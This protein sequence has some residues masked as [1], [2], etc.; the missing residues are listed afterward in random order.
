MKTALQGILEHFEP[1]VETVHEPLLVLDAT[2]QVKLASRAFCAISGNE[3][4]EVI[5]ASLWDIDD[6]YWDVP[7]IRQLLETDLK[8]TPAIRDRRIELESHKRPRQVLTVNARFV[9][10]YGVVLFT[11]ANTTNATNVAPA[12]AESL[13]EELEARVRER[14]QEL[15]DER[16]IALALAEK[17]EEAKVVAIE[18]S[19]ALQRS[20]AQLRQSQK[21]EA[22]GRLAGGV[23][24]DF[25]N[26][27]TVILSCSTF[28]MQDLKPEEQA[29]LDILEIRR[30]ADRAASLTRQLLQF[31][32]KGSIEPQ[33]FNPNEKIA[34]LK[35]MLARLLG[36]DVELVTHLAP[37]LGCVYIDPTA[38]EQIVVNLAVNARDAMP[39]GGRLLIESNVAHVDEGYAAAAKG[40]F[41]PPGEYVTVSVSDTGV[42][43]DLSMQQHIF[44]PFFT[45]K[46]V[47][48]G[49]GLGLST[50][51][52]IAKQA[53]GYVSVYSELGKGT[54]FRVYLAR[55]DMPATETRERR[56]QATYTGTEAVLVVE[57]D[58]QIRMLC[59]RALS[60]AGY[61][62]EVVADGIEALR[63]CED[64][65][66][67]FDLLLT[68][69]VMPGMSGT[70][71][72]S[73]LAKT[74]PDM[75]LLFM[76]GY[77]PNAIAP[78]GVSGSAVA[79][80]A[81]PF[82]LA[83]LTKSIREVLDTTEAS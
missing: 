42:G 67:V 79:L 60:G 11:I 28:V 19:K 6:G 12:G 74:R 13:T 2:M 73:R 17:A 46:E 36:E 62:V 7:G 57:D 54:T 76:S 22:V 34:I 50:V 4:S 39:D 59:K 40:A 41:I 82:T 68:D 48:Q 75:K 56:T 35:L 69:V 25:N 21:M 77:T 63:I 5:G 29:Y 33:L 38:F 45:T 26:L 55:R 9:Q 64:E 65:G 23:A 81:K 1:L 15:E 49:T 31:S 70:Q 8:V 71:L 20:E 37:D 72:A 52:G 47:G 24:H 10:A 14:T 43:M 27:L 53:G 78:H 16:R 32:R 83:G 51:Y 66:R 80:L 58:K 3:S 44:E 18:A 61:Q 30:A